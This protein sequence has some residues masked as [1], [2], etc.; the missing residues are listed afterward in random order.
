MLTEADLKLLIQAQSR[1]SY[2]WKRVIEIARNYAMFKAHGSYLE[3]DGSLVTISGS[4]RPSYETHF[5][6]S[7][8]SAVLNAYQEDSIMGIEIS[9][10][11]T[12]A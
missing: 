7:L 1:Q 6:D 10:A 8:L 12:K 3:S 2:A 9:K 4:D 5:K 11:A